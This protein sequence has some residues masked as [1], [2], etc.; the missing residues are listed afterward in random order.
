[1][2]HRNLGNAFAAQGQMDDAV[3]H[4][5][6]A[7]DIQPDD[8]EAHYNLGDA[9]AARSRLDE[10]VAHYRKALDLATQHNNRPV[11]DAL[12]AK[13]ALY[14]AGT[15]YRQTLSPSAPLPPKP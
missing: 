6:K 14:E 13:I 8:A 11:A 1:M 15:P 4:Y 3:T 2:A 9:F 12:R 7:V 10:A 5:Q